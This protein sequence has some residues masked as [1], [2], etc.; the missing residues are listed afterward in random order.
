VASRLCAMG[1][2]LWPF[3]TGV[4]RPMRPTQQRA[5]PSANP[6]HFMVGANKG[7]PAPP[8]AATCP[9][10]PD[11]AYIMKFVTRAVSIQLW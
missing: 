10:L 4:T 9:S 2:P 8:K 11:F 1:C 5:P 6:G 3:D 7:I